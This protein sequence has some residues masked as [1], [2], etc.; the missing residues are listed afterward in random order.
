MPTHSI[1][2]LSVK[3]ERDSLLSTYACTHTHAYSHIHLHAH[4]HRGHIIEF[5][6]KTPLVPTDCVTNESKGL[7]GE[8]ERKKVV[9][10]VRAVG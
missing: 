8:S 7:H 3:P 5:Y 10:Y 1:S 6:S 9:M 2:N 4:T